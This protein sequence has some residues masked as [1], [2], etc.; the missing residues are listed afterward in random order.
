MAV[1]VDFHATIVAQRR[2]VILSA[3]NSFTPTIEDGYY[4]PIGE[5]EQALVVDTVQQWCQTGEQLFSVALPLPEVRFDQRGRV[6]GSFIAARPATAKRLA[7]A[8]KLRFNPWLFAKYWQESLADTV[9]HEVA[10]YAVSRLYPQRRL[11]PH[12]PQWKAV[13]LAFG[14]PA[15][16][17]GR[18]SV[19]GI[20][21]RQQRSF[22][23]QCGCRSHQLGAVRHRRA[24][25]GCAVYHCRAC[26]GP[27]QASF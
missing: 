13:M 10:H 3:M 14:L 25:R 8:D 26:R 15:R 23:Y 16:A 6:A 19:E 22:T 9:P 24:S 2:L 21:Q 11:K 12:G 4:L 27:L 5:R 18:Y 17:T 1:Q 20:P 7:Q